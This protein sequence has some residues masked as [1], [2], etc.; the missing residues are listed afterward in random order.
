MRPGAPVSNC[1]VHVGGDMVSGALAQVADQQP[2]DSQGLDIW[3][4]SPQIY[5][6]RYTDVV[7]NSIHR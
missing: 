5:P 7:R 4:I 2:W 6:I 3:R 1:E